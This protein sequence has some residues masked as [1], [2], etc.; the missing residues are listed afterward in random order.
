MLYK[1][2][3]KL[4]E[5]QGLTDELKKKIETLH[6]LGKLADEQYHDLIGE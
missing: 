4:I 2:L 5:K 6:E 3:K 1:T